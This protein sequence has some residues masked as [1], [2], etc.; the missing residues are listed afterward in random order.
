EIDGS[1]L[2]TLFL[3]HL[4]AVNDYY[5]LGYKLFF[6]R[7]SNQVEVDFVVYGERGLFAFEVK[8]SRNLSRSDFNGLRAFAEDYKIAKCYLF[9]GGDHEE[10]HGDIHVIPFLHGLSKL[11]EILRGNGG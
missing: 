6:W 9:Y 11:I 5:R 7:T 3:L 4:R 1:A 10:H 2:E 8:R